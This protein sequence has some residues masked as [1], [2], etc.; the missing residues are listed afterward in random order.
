MTDQAGAVALLRALLAATTADQLTV[1]RSAL[2]ALMA[3]DAAP[4]G[5]ASRVPHLMTPDQVAARLGV[6]VGHLYHIWREIPGAVKL[7]ARSLRFTPDGVNQYVAQRP[8]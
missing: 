6:T 8:R 4:D 7:S 1:P 3:P 2:A 5:P